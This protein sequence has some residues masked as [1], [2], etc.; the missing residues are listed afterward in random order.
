MT[1]HQSTTTVYTI[2]PNPSTQDQIP[3]DKA[4]FKA[5]G[6]LR[7]ACFYIEHGWNLNTIYN[8][9]EQVSKLLAASV[10]GEDIDLPEPQPEPIE[11]VLFR[12][13]NNALNAYDHARGAHHL[14]NKETLSHAM[15][16]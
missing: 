12:M 7:T 16:V 11:V 1:D 3:T 2:Q 13:F 10:Q 14:V 8:E 4:L 5:M 9:T 6:T 15:S